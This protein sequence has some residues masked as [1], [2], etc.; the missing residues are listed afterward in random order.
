MNSVPIFMFSVCFYVFYIPVLFRVTDRLSLVGSPACQ[1]RFIIMAWP[2]ATILKAT[3]S[4]VPS[5][6]AGAMASSK[7]NLCQTDV[8]NSSPD[9]A[10]CVKNV[11][12][13]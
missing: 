7:I 8:T 3:P 12:E 11:C 5:P 13:E 4:S 10:M 9:Q 2:T 6:N 1:K